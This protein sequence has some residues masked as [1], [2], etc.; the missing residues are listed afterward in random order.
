MSAV[1]AVGVSSEG[2]AGDDGDVFEE[3]PRGDRSL[4]RTVSLEKS[5]VAIAIEEV[6]CFELA[7]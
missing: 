6:E 2:V 5:Y 1:D 3:I 4:K 7:G